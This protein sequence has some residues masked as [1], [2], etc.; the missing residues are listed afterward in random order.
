MLRTSYGPSEGVGAHLKGEYPL[1]YTACEGLS[2]MKESIL[3][4][5]TSSTR[6]TVLTETTDPVQID[7]PRGREGTFKSKIVAKHRL[8]G[9]D[10]AVFIDAIVV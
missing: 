8:T 3:R 5:R 7:I 4:L 1:A 9:V 6:G 10:V 2:R